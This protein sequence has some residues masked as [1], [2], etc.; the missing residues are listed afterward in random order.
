MY[1][2]S[3]LATQRKTPETIKR[4]SRNGN[5]GFLVDKYESCVDVRKHLSTKGHSLKSSIPSALKT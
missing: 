1:Q 5:Y 4:L 2:E 3:F